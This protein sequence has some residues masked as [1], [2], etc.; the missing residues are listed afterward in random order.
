M[1]EQLYIWCAERDIMLV[2]GAER[3]E[4]DYDN[5]II[6]LESYEDVN[7]E[8]FSL[9]HEI[10][11]YLVENADDYN[12]KYRDKLYGETVAERARGILR[13]EREAWRHGLM[14][15]EGMG[16]RLDTDAYCNLA[17]KCLNDYE[18]WISKEIEKSRLT[19][20]GS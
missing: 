15:A 17:R 13:E 16:L 8:A 20:N 7:E 3:T 9:L 4:Y 6:Y 10:G 5:D 19:H 2:F 1:I 11:H 18:T 12:V 14:L